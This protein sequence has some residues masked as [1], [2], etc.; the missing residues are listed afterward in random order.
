MALGSL[1]YL[2]I[3][4]EGDRFADHILPELRAA[5]K[6]GIIRVVDLFLLKKDENGTIARLEL[7]D[8]RRENANQLAPLADNLLSLLAP[9]DL[10]QLVHDIPKNRSA[11]IL[12][13]E[14]TWAIGLKTAVNR[15]S[16]IV[17]AEGLVPHEVMPELEDVLRAAQQL[18][19]PAM[20]SAATSSRNADSTTSEQ[21]KQ[22]E[23]LRDSKVLTEAEY[24]AAKKEILGNI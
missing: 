6:K 4:F 17:V 9:D 2:V 5:W 24:E 1:E 21:L 18:A 16:G 13:F 8:L 12:L 22:I 10:E 19:P 20:G 3:G 23:A 7:S 14:H 15:A 11:A